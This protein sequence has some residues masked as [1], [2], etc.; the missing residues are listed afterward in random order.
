[1]KNSKLVMPAEWEKQEATWLAWPHHTADWPGKFPTVKWIF[2]E[3]ARHVLASQKLKLLVKNKEVENQVKELCDLVHLDHSGIEFLHIPT[4]RGWMRDCG[5]IFVKNGKQKAFL[6]FRFN[7]WAKYGNHKLDDKVPEL[8]NKKLKLERIVPM[9]KGKKVVLEGGAIDVNGKGLL[10]TTE[11][12]L[13]SNIQERNP[14][15]TKDDYLEVF[16]KYLGIE[17]IIWLKNGIEGDDTHGHVDDITRFVSA[18]TVITAVESNK[19]D[20]NNKHL[21]ENLK[22]L[23]ARKDL[24][25]IELP[26]PEAIN[27]EGYR[28]PASYANFLITNKRVIVPVFNDVNDRIALNIIASAFPKHEVVGINSTDLVLGL[29]TIHCLTQQEP[30]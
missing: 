21:A 7:G 6:D 14:G 10:L 17:E 5:P 24:N 22:I 15:F 29:G 13:Q 26:M 25:V 12:C 1:M 20:H 23:K 16:N 11:E 2:L 27:F 18:D 30:I 4:N 28:L 9:H 19:K 3:I 8:A